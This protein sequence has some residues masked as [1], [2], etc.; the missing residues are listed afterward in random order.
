MLFDDLSMRFDAMDEREGESSIGT[1]SRRRER[2]RKPEGRSVG[3]AGVV[4]EGTESWW[5]DEEGK[6]DA[7]GART[8]RQGGNGGK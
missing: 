7:G 4:G 6:R 1:V 2:G 3:E 5:A 8:A